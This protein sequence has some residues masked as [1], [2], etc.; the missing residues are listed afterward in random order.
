MKQEHKKHL[1]TLTLLDVNS[2][3]A[4]PLFEEFKAEIWVPWRVNFWAHY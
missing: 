3:N 4:Q 1:N 2:S